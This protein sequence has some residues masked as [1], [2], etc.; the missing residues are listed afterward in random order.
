[1]LSP[2]GLVVLTV[3]ALPVAVVL[4]VWVVVTG[5]RIAFP[6]RPLPFVRTDADERRRRTA[7]GEA[8][9][10]GFREIHQDIVEDVPRVWLADRDP[11]G[12][13]AGEAARNHLLRVHRN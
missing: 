12:R 13:P 8:V 9:A 7:S 11:Q 3:V 2:A 4:V 6:E 10:V 1:M 5:W